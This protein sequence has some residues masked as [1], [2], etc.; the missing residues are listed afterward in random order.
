MECNTRAAEASS[1]LST[2][3]ECKPSFFFTHLVVIGGKNPE[4][5][6]ALESHGNLDISKMI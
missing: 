2:I 6:I 5:E 3:S 1:A 4:L